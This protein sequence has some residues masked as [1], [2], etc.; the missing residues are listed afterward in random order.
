MMLQQPVGVAVDAA[1]NMYIADYY[2]NRIRTVSTA[3]IISTFAGN[4]IGGYS[5]DGGQAT[6]AELHDP[7]VAIDAV[8]NVYIADQLNNCIRMVCVSTC[9][10]AGIEEFRVQNSELR[11]WPNPSNSMLNLAISQFDNLKMQDVE[12][13]NTLGELV[14]HCQIAS[15][16]NCQIDVSALPSGVYFIRV[17]TAT[18]KFIKQ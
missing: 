1:G 5:G 9:A 8:G 7:G 12:I 14:Y 17:G 6:A 10:G 2:N 15:S 13:S 3:G 11:I 4:G 16:S 18:Q